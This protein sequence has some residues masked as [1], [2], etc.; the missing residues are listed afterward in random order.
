[1]ILSDTLNQPMAL[2]IYAIF[3]VAFGILYSANY[4]LSTFI[5]KSPL[6]RHLTQVLY[7]LMYSACFFIITYAFFDYS[8]KLYQ[9]AICVV[10]TFGTSALL[11]LP[12]KHWKLAIANKCET[13]VNNIMQSKLAKRFKK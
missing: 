9:L 11:Y 8:L 13:F 3:G 1:M 5:I 4:F 7:V 2:A 10:F 6:Y 12:L